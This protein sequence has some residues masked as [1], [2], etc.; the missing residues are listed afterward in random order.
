M[1]YQNNYSSIYSHELVDA[2]TR[3]RKA[4]FVHKLI[5]A[6]NIT[7]KETQV[8]E[9]GC[10]TGVFAMTL[11]NRYMN[12]TGVDIDQHALQQAVSSVA[13]KELNNVIFLS[14]NA[15][16]LPFA[17]N[18]YDLVICNH[19]Y[20]HI[21]NPEK[22]LSEISRVLRPGGICY[23]SAGNRFALIE[24]HHRVLF[25]SWFPKSI[26]NFVLTI[27]YKRK[28]KYYETHFSRRKLF[29]LLSPYSKVE[30]TPFA[31]EAFIL[32]NFPVGITQFYLLRIATIFF[33]I[34][35]SVCP[36]YIFIIQKN[37]M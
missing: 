24:P 31:I 2:E 33:R 7:P 29:N 11:A 35:P 28:T 22:M 4:E 14:A 34:I 16:D 3:K 13:T 6:T 20:E 5:S 12:W 25:L 27:K 15:E 1:S 32:E 36:T 18:S 21:P 10:H 8:L 17:N 19:I 9:V 30:I 37:V 26:S 23:F